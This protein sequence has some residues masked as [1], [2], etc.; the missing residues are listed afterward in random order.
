MGD[1]LI[2]N[3]ETP[4]LILGEDSILIAAEIEPDAS[5]GGAAATALSMSLYRRDA[6]GTGQT[7]IAFL[8]RNGA[9]TTAWVAFRPKSLAVVRNAFVAAG[10]SITALATAGVTSFNGKLTLHLQKVPS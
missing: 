6:Q 3:V 2:S 10:E 4:V 5:T 7:L 9:G 1:Q 8:D